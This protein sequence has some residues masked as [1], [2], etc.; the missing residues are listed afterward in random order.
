MMIDV[1]LLLQTAR[2]KRA[3]YTTTAHPA[4]PVAA[5]VSPPARSRGRKRV[6]HTYRDELEGLLPAEQDPRQKAIR[7]GAKRAAE[8][9]LAKQAREAKVL[10]ARV[11]T[12]SERY[13]ARRAKR[14]ARLTYSRAYAR[15][16]KG[17]V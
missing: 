12:E 14:A 11:E 2:V 10:V 15:K 4:A 8:R 9:R 7:Q 16:A 6:A 13:A 3:T 1:F 5:V 17:A